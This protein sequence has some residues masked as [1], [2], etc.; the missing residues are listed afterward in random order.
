M[1]R[2]HDEETNLRHY[3]G[4][5]L[6]PA[7]NVFETGVGYYWGIH[8]TRDFMRA[9]YG[10]LTAL[11]EFDTDVAVAK[12]LDEALDYI[13][14]N[15]SDSVGVR[16][17]ASA[18]Y[19]RLGRIQECYDFIK[20]CAKQYAEGSNDEE[21][22]RRHLKVRDADLTEPVDIF[23]EFYSLPH[24]S[25]LTFIKF[26]V[27]QALMDIANSQEAS[28]NLP[29]AVEDTVTAFL[30]FCELAAASP[31]P[32]ELQKRVA[33]QAKEA[34]KKAHMH[35]KYFWADN[36]DPTVVM[37]Q[38]NPPYISDDT[39]DEVRSCLGYIFSLWHSSPG[40][41][42]FVRRNLSESQ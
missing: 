14:L 6:L 21:E 32:K 27:A 30:P 40:A 11:L 25:A 28:A 4:G 10:Y 18:L 39:V 41:L 17:H 3:P 33:A 31:N 19:L 42:E 24:L 26:H 8:G 37:R 5:G 35:N 38:P 12:A 9:K 15:I 7:G 16:A 1:D 23:P 22:P 34:F 29:A 2:R 13:R 20:G 36:L